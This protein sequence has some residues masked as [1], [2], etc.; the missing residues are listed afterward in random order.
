MKGVPRLLTDAVNWQREY[1]FSGEMQNEYLSIRTD[2]DPWAVAISECCGRLNTFRRWT[3]QN[4][5]EKK[6]QKVQ[7][8]QNLSHD[9]LRFNKVL[10]HFQEKD[11]KD[12]NTDLIFLFL[13]L[14]KHSGSDCWCF[15]D[16]LKVLISFC[17]PTSYEGMQPKDHFCGATVKHVKQTLRTRGHVR[18]SSSVR[19]VK[20]SV[21]SQNVR[22]AELSDS[23]LGRPRAECLCGH[24]FTSRRS[25]VTD[26]IRVVL[27]LG[28]VSAPNMMPP[29]YC[30]AGQ[31]STSR[32]H[33][34]PQTP[35]LLRS[36]LPSDP[37]PQCFQIL[38]WT[39][40]E[41][42]HTKPSWTEPTESR[43]SPSE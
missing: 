20:F 5:S 41:S 35:S 2:P 34:L 40:S 31:S 43:L 24:T 7:L 26:G 33:L 14:F 25:C 39:V 23:G 42:N 1:T 22:I 19:D 28:L 3:V 27:T 12:V 15:T 16:L 30:P 8:S 29:P 36:S 21:S 17:R 9:L 10:S 6:N 37:D 32:T 38:P 4:K 18:F 13:Y 11:V